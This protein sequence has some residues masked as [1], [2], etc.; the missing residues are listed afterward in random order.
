MIFGCFFDLNDGISDT[1]SQPE[2]YISWIFLS[3]N[4]MLYAGKSSR[5]RFLSKSPENCP[6]FS[7]PL[8]VNLYVARYLRG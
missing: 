5:H 8:T 2:V 6:I 7:G 1:I 3:Q 4:L